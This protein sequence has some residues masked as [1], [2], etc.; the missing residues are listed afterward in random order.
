MVRKLLLVLGVLAAPSLFAHSFG[1]N[2]TTAVITAINPA[3]FVSGVTTPVVI[4]GSG[5]VA[6]AALKAGYPPDSFATTFVS[7][8]EL[9]TNVFFYTSAGSHVDLYVVNPSANDSNPFT[10]T[11]TPAPPP[12]P[13]DITFSGND[14]IGKVTPGSTAY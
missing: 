11:V 5:F 10:V 1:V 3:S 4:T 14:V 6:G 13:A 2:G 8:Q 9:H 7:D 12:P